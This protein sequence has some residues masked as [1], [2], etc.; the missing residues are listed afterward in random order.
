M[1]TPS[2]SGRGFLRG[3]RSIR[4][5][6]ADAWWAP[7]LHERQENAKDKKKDQRRGRVRRLGAGK[8]RRGEEDA[9]IRAARICRENGGPKP[10]ST[11]VEAELFPELEA[12]LCTESASLD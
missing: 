6:S 2:S 8:E 12:L 1:S 4:E 11:F 3:K 5:S 7:R 9:R 10:C